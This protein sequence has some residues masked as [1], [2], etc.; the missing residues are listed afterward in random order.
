M[1]GGRELDISCHFHNGRDWNRET[2]ATF[3]SSHLVKCSTPAYSERDEDGWHGDVTLSV[4]PAG[5][6]GHEESNK[7]H[8][9]RGLAAKVELCGRRAIEHPCRRPSHCGSPH[10]WR[11]AR[12]AGEHARR[13]T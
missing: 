10:V 5:E 1:Q 11:E 13:Y 7:V 3:L 12:G 4:G 2:P 6:E 9:A 8:F